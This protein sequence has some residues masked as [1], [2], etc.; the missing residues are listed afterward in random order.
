MLLGIAFA[1]SAGCSRE[2]ALDVRDDRTAHVPVGG[3]GIVLDDIDVVEA[4]TAGQEGKGELRFINGIPVLTVAGTPEEMGTQ[5]AALTRKPMR[6]MFAYPRRYLDRYGVASAWPAVI[7]LGK[8]MIREAPDNHRREMQA[9]AQAAGIDWDTMIAGNT[10]PDIKKIGGCSTLIIEPERSATGQVLFGRNLDYPTLGLLNHYSLV[11]AYRPEGKHAFAS[12][13]F[14]GFVG[15]LSGMNDAG[16]ALAVLEI[17]ASKD[18][19]PRFTNGTPYA[20]CFRRLLEECATVSEAET[21]LRSLK[22]TTWVSLAIADRER[23]AVFEITPKS[24]VVRSAENG[25]CPCTNHFRSHEL[26]KPTGCGRYAVLARSQSMKQLDLAAVRKLLHGAN[27]GDFTFQT[28]IFEPASLRLHLAIGD[29]PTSALEPRLLELGPLFR[30]D[31]GTT[32]RP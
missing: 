5:L 4:Y 17:G 13:G 7:R 18:G 31:A 9:I 30:G 28:M 2:P 24:V 15:C 12:I 11:T 25:I 21:L 8:R 26:G 22:R 27:Q 10:M 3:A 20:M 23:G 1:L 32:V 6:R 29:C 16:L 19:S 14:P